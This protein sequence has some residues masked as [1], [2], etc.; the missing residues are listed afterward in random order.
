MQVT[1]SLES[2][3]KWLYM[4]FQNLFMCIFQNL[5]ELSMSI[6]LAFPELSNQVDI[7]QVK[8]SIYIYSVTE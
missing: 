7:E 4:T 8:T 3:V 6:S 1:E 2:I 5:P